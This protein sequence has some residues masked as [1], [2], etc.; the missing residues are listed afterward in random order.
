MTTQHN[1]KNSENLIYFTYA[2]KSRTTLR[3]RSVNSYLWLLHPPQVIRGTTS[4][5]PRWDK[6]VNYVE[7]SLVYATGRLFVDAHFQE[8]RKQMVR[9]LFN[10]FYKCILRRPM[11][12][13]D[14]LSRL[15]LE[16]HTVI[17]LCRTS[18]F[19]ISDGRADRGDPVGIR[20]HA[21]EG[22]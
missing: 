22:K 5:T 17:Y 15:L 16:R 11:G 1:L 3:G 14:V 13:C 4:L 20:R 6:C 2:S 8:D 10:L 21:G 7:N 18:M 9:P 12:G 19:D